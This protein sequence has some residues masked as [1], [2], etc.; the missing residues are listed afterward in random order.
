MILKYIKAL[1][2]NWCQC[3]SV[4]DRAGA[5]ED[6]KTITVGING[7]ESIEEYPAQGEG[8]KWNYLVKFE[9][10]RSLRIFNPNTV[11]YFANPS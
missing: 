3:G 7:V 10:G 4:Q 5:G 1:T 9:D 8:D 11:E 2:Y 6:W